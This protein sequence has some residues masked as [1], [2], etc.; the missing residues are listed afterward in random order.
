METL[1]DGT[2]NE[3]SKSCATDRTIDISP[4]GP[5]YVR[6]FAEQR[7]PNTHKSHCH[8]TSLEHSRTLLV[9]SV[10]RQYPSLIRNAPIVPPASVQSTPWVNNTITR[11]WLVKNPLQ[12]SSR[13][14][15]VDTSASF[16]RGESLSI[17]CAHLTLA[18][19]MMDTYFGVRTRDVGSA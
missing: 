2:K 6:S 3:T 15:M 19:L 14:Q 16:G 5:I 11:C 9:S 12:R 10:A 7:L 17:Q 8:H 13:N 18:H 1:L 4:R